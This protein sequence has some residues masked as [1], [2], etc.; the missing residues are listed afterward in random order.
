LL[1]EQDYSPTIWAAPWDGQ[2]VLADAAPL[3]GGIASTPAGFVQW[4]DQTWFSTDGITWTASPLPAGASWVSGAFNID[5]GLIVLASAES[6]E[7]VVYRVDERGE[8]AV[9]LELPVPDSSSLSMTS[10]FGG[11]ATSGAVVSVDPLATSDERLSVDVDGYRLALPGAAGIFEVTDLATGEVIVSEN[12]FGPDNEGGW[13]TMDEAGIT[14]TDPTTGEV[15]VVFSQDALDSAESVYFDQGGG[16]YNPDFW[17]LASLDGER[18]VLEDLDD[19]TDGPIS[20]V[21]NGSR[22]LLQSGG[23]WIT[24]DLA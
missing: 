16:E 9:L 8:N 23:N 10:S 15:L 12:L 21:T 11:S 22:L 20:A 7:S 17:L 5:G 1:S 14:V 2:P 3:G 6:G 24:Y 19:V 4:T 13:L 18:F